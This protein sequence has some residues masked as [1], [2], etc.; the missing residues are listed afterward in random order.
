MIDRTGQLWEYR[1]SDTFEWRLVVVIRSE[2]GP[3]VA[4]YVGGQIFHTC[5]YVK[6][7]MRTDLIENREK[8]DNYWDNHSYCFR[9]VA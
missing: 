4:D 6:E 2:W 1:P 5:M 9:R 8:K 3:H 7:L